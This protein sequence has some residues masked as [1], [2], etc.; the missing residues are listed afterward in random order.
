MFFLSSF[1]RRYNIQN[2]NNGSVNEYFHKSLEE[3]SENSP[4]SEPR[5]LVRLA[6]RGLLVMRLVRSMQDYFL[7]LNVKLFQLC[8]LVPPRHAHASAHLSLK[9]SSS[10]P[11][12]CVRRC[13]LQVLTLNKLSK[14]RE[15][16]HQ[17]ESSPDAK[18][19]TSC[20]NKHSTVLVRGIPVTGSE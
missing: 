4:A 18:K 17:F 6:K 1:C 9:W 16:S 10:T 19:D 14:Q 7:V 2:I 8:S 15:G 3:S 13:A 5:V 12:T 11:R 20:R